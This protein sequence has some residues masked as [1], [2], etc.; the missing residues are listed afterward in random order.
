VFVSLHNSAYWYEEQVVCSRLQ[1]LQAPSLLAG[2]S[3]VKF[4]GRWQT[5]LVPDLRGPARTGNRRPLS[6]VEANATGR[7]NSKKNLTLDPRF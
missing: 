1:D 3:E 4:R 5:K 7:Y 2:L 6:A